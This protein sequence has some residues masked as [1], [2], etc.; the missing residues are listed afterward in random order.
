[1]SARHTKEQELYKA[2]NVDHEIFKNYLKR[3][4]KDASIKAS[5]RFHPDVYKDNFT[6]FRTQKAKPSK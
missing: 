3:V 1:M 6:N 5:C 4:P 2:K